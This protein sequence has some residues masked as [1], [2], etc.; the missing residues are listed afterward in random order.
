MAINLPPPPIQQSDQNSFVWLEWYRQF[1]DFLNTNGSVPWSLVDKTGSNLTDI[2]TRLHNQLQGLQGGASNN[3]F[4]LRRVLEVPTVIDFPNITTVSTATQTV[5][6][7]G[8]TTADTVIV[9]PQGTLEAGLVV[10]GYVSSSNTVTV[11]A[12]NPTAGSIN[13]ASR[14]YNIMVLKGT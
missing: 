1:R 8:A 11:V 3:F 2:A 14:T 7:T 4:H 12:T 9:T 13:P 6:A 10:Y 5:T